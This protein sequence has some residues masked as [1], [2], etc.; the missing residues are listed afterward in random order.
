MKYTATCLLAVVSLND[1]VEAAMHMSRSP[2]D[3]SSVP[4]M[5]AQLSHYGLHHGAPW[6][7][8][9]ETCNGWNSQTN[10]AFSPCEPN[11][12][13]ECVEHGRPNTPLG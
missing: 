11:T 1:H 5:Y 10:T 9:G 13:I 2:A 6:A 12:C 3:M 8:I 7:Q 4:D